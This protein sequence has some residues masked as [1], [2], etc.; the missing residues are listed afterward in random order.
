MRGTTVAVGAVGMDGRAVSEAVARQIERAVV[1]KS[2]VTRLLLTALI[3]D[4]HVLLV[5]VPGVAKTRVTRALARSLDLGF[6]RIQGTPDLLPGDV[7][8]VSVYDPRSGDFRYRPGPVLTQLVLVDEVNRATPR[9][10]S[11]L[12]ECMEEHQVTVDGTT[13][14]VPE[15]FMVLAT[16][17][18]IEMEGTYPLPEAQLDRFL[19]TTPIGY[20]SLADETEMVSRLHGSDPLLDLTPLAGPDEVVA[21]RRAA[22]SVRLEGP[23]EQYLVEVV[24]AT[25]EHADVR[26]G[27]SPRATVALSRAVRAWA[28]LSGREFAIPD[29]VKALA[30][31]VLAHRLLLR[32]DAEVLGKTSQ[33][34]IADVLTRVT[35]P[36]EVP[37]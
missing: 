20:P 10:Q 6:A 1:G 8:G 3:A 25:R 11:A 7:V 23:V 5:D 34:V 18:P 12:L 2:H 9:T 32:A 22:Q 4:G 33:E 16:Q 31:P 26:L 28:W 27:A 37:Q 35:V 30:I 13:Y 17:N 29:D 19:M 36:T 14:P 15:P 21:W 24:R